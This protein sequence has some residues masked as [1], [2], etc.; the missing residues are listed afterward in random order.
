MDQQTSLTALQLF[1]EMTAG[2]TVD[3]GDSSAK[4][5]I[6]HICIQLKFGQFTAI[7]FNSTMRVDGKGG[8]GFS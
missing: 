8:S 4:T 5:R 3:D 1:T 7:R 6:Y 2:M